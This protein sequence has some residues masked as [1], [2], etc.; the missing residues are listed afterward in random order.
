MI[1]MPRYPEMLAFFGILLF[2]LTTNIG[3]AY[4]VNICLLLSVGATVFALFIAF[5]DYVIHDVIICVLLILTISLLQL[6]YVPTFLLCLLIFFRIVSIEKEYT[7]LLI[8]ITLITSTLSCLSVNLLLPDLILQSHEQNMLNALSLTL[9]AMV[10]F[11]RFY[12]FIE[13]TE[14]FKVEQQQQ[15]RRL[16]ENI[17]IIN[18]LSK[19]LPPQVANPIIHSKGNMPLVVQRHKL[20]VLF[21]DIVGFTELSDTISPDELSNILN[22]YMEKMTEIAYRYEATLDKFMGDG[23]LC[24][25]GDHNHRSDR[26]NAILCAK[27]AIEMRREM[28]VLG[29]KWRLLGFNGLSLRIGINTGYCHVGCFGSA[30]RM[31]YSLIGQESNLA[32]RLESSARP[33]QILISDS[34]YQLIRHSQYCQIIGKLELKGFEEA[35]KVWELLDPDPNRGYVVDNRWVTHDLPGFN[36]HLNL[37]ELRNYDKETVIEHL[38]NALD[39]VETHKF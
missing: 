14:I 31:N 30:K 6:N 21:S 16:N 38:N 26:E 3:T 33:N 12:Y 35:V 7:L 28:F 22:T 23:L 1:K 27:M 17:L 18:K 34:T 11:Y 9:V 2:L 29:K 13:L 19:F 8:I 24:F 37:E 15:Q 39:I 25:F 5:P 32:S 4:F 10:L 20:T 36:I